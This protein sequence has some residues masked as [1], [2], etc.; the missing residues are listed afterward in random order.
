MVDGFSDLD[1][2]QL[3]HAWSNLA[4][5]LQLSW[6]TQVSAFTHYLLNVVHNFLLGLGSTPIKTMIFFLQFLLH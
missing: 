2:L 3:S 5:Q 4:C 6:S 1:W